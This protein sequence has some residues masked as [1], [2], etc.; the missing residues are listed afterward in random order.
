VENHFPF[1]VVEGLDGTG[2]TTARKGLFRLLEGVYGVTPLAVLTANFLA[3]EAAGAIVAG[4]YAPSAQNRDAYLAALIA[5]KRAS[6][7]ELIEPAL[8]VRPVIADRWLLSEMGFFA[9]KHH[10][11][12]EET[13]QAL[14]GA[15]GRAPDVT[16]VLS[17]PASTSMGRATGR[18]GGDSV[19]EDWDTASVQEPLKALYDAVLDRPGA[20]PGLGT[21]VR[22]DSARSRAGVL[23]SC[24]TALLDL[25]LVPALEG[26]EA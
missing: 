17:A 12:P 22:I 3:P 4:K 18:T 15:L 19:R 20:Y 21:V 26:E 10:R 7:A 2:K 25:G 9:V 6:L 24:W 23:A 16:L 14:A 5:D 13:Y 1:I 8:T 11:P